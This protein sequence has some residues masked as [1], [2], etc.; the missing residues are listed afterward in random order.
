MYRARALIRV[1]PEGWNAVIESYARLKEIARERGW[2][3]MTIWTQTFGPF[4]ELV[5]ETDYPDLATYERETNAFF[6][7][8]EC[9]KLTMEAM[10]YR[11]PGEPGH[12]EMWQRAE[13]VAVD[14]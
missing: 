12:N 1:T 11:S 6:A 4:G 3:E 2:Q 5:L 10:N 14:N 13:P 9:M 7:D 8:D